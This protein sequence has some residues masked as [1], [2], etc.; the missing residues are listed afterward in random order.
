[1][2]SFLFSELSQATKYRFLVNFVTPRP[3]AVVST[4]NNQGQGNLAPFSFFNAVASNPPTVMFSIGWDENGNKKDT[5]NNIEQVGEFVVN[6]ASAAIINKVVECAAKYP[7]GTDEMVAVGLTPNP[8][9][10]VKPRRISESPL[11]LECKVT[12]LIEIGDRNTVGAT[13]VVFGEVLMAHIIEEAMLA[14]KI[15][16]KA[17]D[18]VGRLGGISYTK[19]GEILN[20]PIPQL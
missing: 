16:P 1:M 12:K 13:V 20:I 11:Q 9:T 10:I 3:I 17:L 15:N 19:L 8:S 2:K 14:D 4:I 5:L 6:F 7:Y 18:L